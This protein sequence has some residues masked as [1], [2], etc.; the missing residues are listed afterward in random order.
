MG[1]GTLH[2]I[3]KRLHSR[4][5]I[6]SIL[7]N[8]GEFLP[9][10]AVQSFFCPYLTSPACGGGTEGALRGWRKCLDHFYD[11]LQNTIIIDTL[12]LS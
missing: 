7:Q 4:F 5:R 1:M 2:A 8:C 9:Y 3:L 12:R 10:Q 6:Y 11:L